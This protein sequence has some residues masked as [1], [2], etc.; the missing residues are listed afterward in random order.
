L[1]VLVDAGQLAVDDPLV[2]QGLDPAALACFEKL[3]NEEH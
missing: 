1:R 2:R 3:S